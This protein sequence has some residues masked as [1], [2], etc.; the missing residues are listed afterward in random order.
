MAATCPSEKIVCE[1][2][3]QDHLMANC[4]LRGKDLA[5]YKCINCGIYGH[6]ARDRQC[7]TFVKLSLELNKKNPENLFKYYVIEGDK[8]TYELLH[9]DAADFTGAQGHLYKQQ[10]E[11]EWMEVNGHKHKQYYY[12]LNQKGKGKEHNT[13]V[14]ISQMVAAVRATMIGPEQETMED[15][16]IRDAAAKMASLA[17]VKLTDVG[18]TNGGQ[19]ASGS[20]LNAN[21]V[22]P[23]SLT[24]RQ[25]YEE[26]GVIAD[27]LNCRSEGAQSGSN[28]DCEYV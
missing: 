6:S 12:H 13:G 15:G 19:V 22:I 1:L 27:T 20:G 7:L 24:G 11:T 23:V 8:D 5:H 21:N 2:C 3:G 14:W 25:N 16:E 26:E 9:P 10:Q 18:I 17:Q 4:E 28:T